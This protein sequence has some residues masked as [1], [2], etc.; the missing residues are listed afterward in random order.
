MRSLRGLCARLLVFQDKA[1]KVCDGVTYLHWFVGSL[2]TWIATRNTYLSVRWNLRV[3]WDYKGEERKGWAT[4]QIPKMQ[5]VCGW[6]EVLENVFKTLKNILLVRG[7]NSQTKTAASGWRGQ[8]LFE[9]QTWLKD[10]AMQCILKARLLNALLRSS[11]YLHTRRFWCA[12]SVAVYVHLPKVTHVN[13]V[14]LNL[15]LWKHH[16]AAQWTSQTL[17]G[18]L[19]HWYMTR[20]LLLKSSQF[21]KV[22]V[23][24]KQTC[25]SNIPRAAG[26]SFWCLQ[27]QLQVVFSIISYGTDIDLRLEVRVTRYQYLTATSRE[28]TRVSHKTQD[29]SKVRYRGRGAL[30]CRGSKQKLLNTIQLEYLSCGIPASKL[31]PGPRS[32]IFTLACILRV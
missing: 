32:A 9:L 13:Y 10:R 24:V 18:R 28:K 31:P 21:Q 6:S 25:R 30:Q 8:L 1:C 12:F 29:V 7:W 15:F 19:K 2:R 17:C 27:T 5:F 20:N 16:K 3:T 11:C 23:E 14:T 26:N 22:D 4:L